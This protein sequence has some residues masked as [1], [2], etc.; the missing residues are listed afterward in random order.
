VTSLHIVVVVPTPLM[1]RRDQ[2][3][4]LA[5]S[6]GTIYTATDCPIDITH[7]IREI[8]KPD[9]KLYDE[10]FN[11]Y[12][13]H[14]DPKVM[15]GLAN[16]I[17]GTPRKQYVVFVCT[18]VVD[19]GG[20]VG[21]SV[22]GEAVSCLPV[23]AA[24]QTIGPHDGKTWAHEIAHGLNQSHVDDDKNLMHASLHNADGGKAG[25][26]LTGGQGVNMMVHCERLTE[27]GF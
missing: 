12:R 3:G 8:A 24:K 25:A 26:K 15:T 4:M 18:S 1:G 2:L 11:V 14:F 6:V 23:P 10:Q 7:E 22:T 17:V 19:A 20:S 13:Q 5:T 27:K 21:F 9:G 16:T